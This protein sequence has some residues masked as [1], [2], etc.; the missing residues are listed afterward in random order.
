MRPVDDR[1]SV[2]AMRMPLPE[3]AFRVEDPREKPAP[4]LAPGLE[5]LR[6]VEPAH[7]RVGS[8]GAAGPRPRF[9]QLPAMPSAAKR[10]FA[11]RLQVGECRAEAM[12]TRR[13]VAERQ[14]AAT[15]RADGSTIRGRSR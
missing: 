1:R 10:M 2:F 7:D 13:R 14:R 6:S 11:E 8:P 5:R 15:Y 4:S 3:A 12:Q 9:I